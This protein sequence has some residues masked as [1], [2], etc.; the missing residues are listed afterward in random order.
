MP[1]A[2]LNALDSCG[3]RLPR[4]RLTLRGV[5]NGATFAQGDTVIGFPSG[6]DFHLR[7]ARPVAQTNC[8]YKGRI[9][10]FQANRPKGLHRD[11]SPGLMVN[12]HYSSSFQ[13]L[14]RNCPT[15]HEQSGFSDSTQPMVF[16]GDTPNPPAEK[17]LCTLFSES[18]FLGLLSV[19]P[20]L[21]FPTKIKA[22]LRVRPKP[23]SLKVKRLHPAAVLPRR[24][25]QGA[26]GLDL[27]ACLDGGGSVILGKHPVLIGTGIALEI[28]PGYDVQVRPRS[29]LSARGVGVTF[30]TIDSDYRGEVKVT[31]YL[32]GDAESFEVKH[33]D[34]IAQLVITKLADLPLEEVAEL[35]P[36]ERGSGGHGSTGR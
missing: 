13:T 22:D 24:S 12:R 26:S 16:L 29:G 9:R 34:R 5:L 20:I 3:I 18:L 27:Y 28:P 1:H 33:G 10:F 2:L 32:F 30:G 15:P 25:T 21:P 4:G 14:P 35:S 7:S 31:M 36:T 19:L 8:D 11:I 17:C 6:L 23:P